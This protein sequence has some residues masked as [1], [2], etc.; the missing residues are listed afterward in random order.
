MFFLGL[1]LGRSIEGQAGQQHEIIRVDRC[2]PQQETNLTDP[3]LGP[4]AQKALRSGVVTFYLQILTLLFRNSSAGCPVN[5]FPAKSKDGSAS[6]V[7]F[8]PP[9]QK[10]TVLVLQF[11]QF[12]VA[13]FPL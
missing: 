2:A 7:T 10:R 6:T 1:K 5:Q 12:L 3:D 4:V 9:P 13:A 8:S 11:P